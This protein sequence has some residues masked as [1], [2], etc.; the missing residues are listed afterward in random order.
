MKLVG[1]E[2]RR[3]DFKIWQEEE[4]RVTCVWQDSRNFEAE[5]IKAAQNSWK[6]QESLGHFT[7]GI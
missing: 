6:L 3:N 1:N 7:E 2:K 4:E 5:V